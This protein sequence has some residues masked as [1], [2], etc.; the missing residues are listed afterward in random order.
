[1]QTKMDIFITII[2]KVKS[3]ELYSKLRPYKANVTDLGDKVLV[4]TKIDI[5]EDDIE[6]IVNICKDYGEMSV[7]AHMA[8]E[9]PSG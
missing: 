6:H 1:M 9:S 8:K 4:T 7:K 3:L 2:P 5:R